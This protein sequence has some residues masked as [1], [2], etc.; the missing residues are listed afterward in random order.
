VPSSSV[1]RQ[2]HEKARM[3]GDA[4]VIV[5]TPVAGFAR[6]SRASTA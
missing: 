2:L 3:L 4:A 5:H 1:L 6:V